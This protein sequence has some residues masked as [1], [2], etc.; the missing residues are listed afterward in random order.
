LIAT[1]WYQTLLRRE[2]GA[3][4]RGER[5]EVIGEKAGDER[6]GRFASV[7]EAKARKGDGWS[8]Y[9]YTL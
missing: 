2:N 9:R 6:N 3:R 1:V 5:D 7:A 8:G 4:D